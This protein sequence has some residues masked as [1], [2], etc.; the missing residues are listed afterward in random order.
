MCDYILKCVHVLCTDFDSQDSDSDGGTGGSTD[1]DGETGGSTD[2]D[3]GT[4][5]ST[6][7]DGE[8]GA[9]TDTDTDTGSTDSDGMAPGLY[10]VNTLRYS[11]IKNRTFS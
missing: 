9:S 3:G 5:G 1:S 8:T 11:V 6:D 4:D 7:S 2:S 10:L